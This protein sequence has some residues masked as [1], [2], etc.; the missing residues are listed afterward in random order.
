[1]N[2]LRGATSDPIEKPNEYAGLPID[3]NLLQQ[4]SVAVQQVRFRRT[5]SGTHLVERR[6]GGERR[7]CGEN[8]PPG[9][10]PIHGPARISSA[11]FGDS[12]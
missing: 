7:Q 2:F 10:K 4:R 11:G 6:R 8:P 12:P 5:P 3:P 1:M 9:E